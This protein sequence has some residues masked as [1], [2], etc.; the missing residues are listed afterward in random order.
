MGL[1]VI[2]DKTMTDDGARPSLA[3]GDETWGLLFKAAFT[4]SKRHFDGGMVNYRA[5]AERVS[6]LVPVSSTTILRLGTVDVIED[7]NPATRQVAYLSLMALG[8]DPTEFGLTHRDRALRGLTDQ[9]I[10]KMLDPGYLEGN[11]HDG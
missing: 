3:R 2:D 7:A 10:R 1:A 9:E 5:L 8:Y 4:Q 11:G 6:Q